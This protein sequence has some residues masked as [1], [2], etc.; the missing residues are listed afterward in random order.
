MVKFFTPLR[1]GLL[2]F[3]FALSFW[4]GCNKEEST[5]SLVYLNFDHTVDGMELNLNDTWYNCA[6]GHQFQ[7]ARLKYYTSN[8]ALENTAS[9]RIELREVHYRDVEEPDTR[10]FE[11]KNVPPGEYTALSFVFGLDETVNVDN[12]LPNTTTNINMEWPLPGDQGY[13]Y[14]KLE[15]RY[16]L[17]GSG[18]IK[19]FNLHTGATIKTM[20][21]CTYRSNT[22]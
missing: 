18:V 6:A 13:H 12:G 7:V 4:Y 15:G 2:A 16:D 10:T 9:E 20:C 5:A 21:K 19:P 17:N 14:M 1:A 11:W 8:F 22:R 3:T